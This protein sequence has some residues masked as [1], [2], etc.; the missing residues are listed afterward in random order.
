MLLRELVIDASGIINLLGGGVA[1]GTLGSIEPRS[2][3]TPAI[4]TE[5]N[6]KG[7]TAAGFRALLE[8]GLLERCEVEVSAEELTSF[9]ETHELGLGESEAILACRLIGRDLWCD[10]KRARNVATDMLGNERVIGTLGI[11]YQLVHLR[12]LNAVDAFTSYQAMIAAGGFLPA[13]TIADFTAQIPD[14]DV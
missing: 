6:A 11:L 10:D 4:E 5:C 3:V 8:S 9:V 14:A 7:E 13:K 1:A 12:E 2:E